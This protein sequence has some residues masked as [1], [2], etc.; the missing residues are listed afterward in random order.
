MQP[1]HDPWSTGYGGT[2]SPEEPPELTPE[3]PYRITEFKDIKIVLGG[4]ME[5]SAQLMTIDLD[6]LIDYLDN[7][8]DRMDPHEY[9]LSFEALQ[10]AREVAIAAR[11]YR[12]AV[13]R[14][15]RPDLA[16][17]ESEKKLG[18]GSN[19]KRI[20]KK[21]RKGPDSAAVSSKDV[22][23]DPR[24]GAGADGPDREGPAQRGRQRGGRR[25]SRRD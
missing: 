23:G 19:K 1:G 22:G 10:E 3:N 5:L 8:K 21:P 17:A 14:N 9:L 4:L 13:I 7:I 6:S 11:V 15:V 20:E 24:E 18:I 12:D 16:M 25:A 2:T